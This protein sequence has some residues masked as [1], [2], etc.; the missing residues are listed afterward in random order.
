MGRAAHLAEAAAAERQRLAAMTGT[1]L[2]P[3]S[4]QHLEAH[5]ARTAREA[6]QL[7]EDER[8]ARTALDQSVQKLDQAQHHYARLHAS[9]KKLDEVIDR[10]KKMR[11]SGAS[12][13]G[14]ADDSE[15]WPI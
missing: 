2:E 3:A 10:S 8:V 6:V 5:R 12:P 11:A 1:M 14:S 4:L 7:E 13:S 15:E 9:G